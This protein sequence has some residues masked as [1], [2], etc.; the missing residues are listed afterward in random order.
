LAQ[1]FCHGR[2]SKGNRIAKKPDFKTLANQ[3]I[4][5]NLAGRA[6]SRAVWRLVRVLRAPGIPLDR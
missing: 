1:A 5:K 3:G 2:P 6:R 4:D